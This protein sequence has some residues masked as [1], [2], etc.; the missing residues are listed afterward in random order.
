MSVLTPEQAASALSYRAACA[1][2]GNRKRMKAL[3]RVA[4][5]AALLADPA[6]A[7]A[8]RMRMG[9]RR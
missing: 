2:K 9:V 4:R 3:N 8:L 6:V 7:D 5:H 1:S